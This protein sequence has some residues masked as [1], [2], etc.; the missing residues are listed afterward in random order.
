MSGSGSG[1]TTQAY[2]G[3]PVGANSLLFGATQS[4]AQQ[5]TVTLSSFQA[6]NGCISPAFW[7]IDFSGHVTGGNR[8]IAGLVN[9]TVITLAPGASA[10][11]GKYTYRML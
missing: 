10:N 2:E 4:G 9:P 11:V 7:L 1:R 3:S 6:G 5:D 8:V